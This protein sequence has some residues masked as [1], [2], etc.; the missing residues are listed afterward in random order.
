MLETKP[1]PPLLSIM[2]IIY[3]CIYGL[4]DDLGDLDLHSI[5]Q[6]TEYLNYQITV[7]LALI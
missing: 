4:F 2:Q 6:T 5:T 1:P 3:T 7:S